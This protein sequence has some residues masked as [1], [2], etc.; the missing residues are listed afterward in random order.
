[1]LRSLDKNMRKIFWVLFFIKVLFLPLYAAKINVIWQFDRA[2]SWEQDWL[3]ELL[4]GFEVTHIDDGNYKIFLNN[5]LVVVSGVHNFDGHKQYFEKL[6]AMNYA[7][8]VILLSDEGY[9]APTD[10]YEQVKFVFRNYWHKKFASYK[11][12]Y[13]FPLGYKTGFWKNCS[14]YVKDSQY[15]NYT[16]SFAGQMIGKPTREAM[17]N[18]MKQIQNYHIHEIFTWADKNGLPVDAYQDLLLNTIFVPCPTGWWNLDTFR[19]YEALECGCIPIVEKNPID[20]FGLYFG[21]HPFLVVESWDE[22]PACINTLLSDPIRLEK[23]RVACHQWWLDHK[24]KV[25]NELRL[26]IQKTLVR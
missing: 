3:T 9:H 22:A 25:K 2:I 23:R 7:C 14:R 24:E 16:W 17:L 5:S 11:E 6:H 20:Y 4:D 1:M 13:T 21:Q 26:L 10:F 18:A 12:V 19:L 8:G 15:R